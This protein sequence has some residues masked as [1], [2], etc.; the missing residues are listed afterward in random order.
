MSF[1]LSRLFVGSLGPSL[2]AALK[3]ASRSEVAAV[4][5]VPPIAGQGVDG[6]DHVIVIDL[7][8]SGLAASHAEAVSGRGMHLPQHSHAPGIVAAACSAGGVSPSAVPLA[9]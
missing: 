8:L 9:A 1:C 7:E 4:A 2:S 5:H 3:R 6:S